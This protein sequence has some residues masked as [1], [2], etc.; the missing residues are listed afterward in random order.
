MLGFGGMVLPAFGLPPRRLPASEQPKAFG[1][2]AVSLIVTAWVKGAS[3]AFA[4][5]NS[6]PWS[7]AAAFWVRMTIAHGRVFSQGT[8]RGERVNVLLGRLVIKKPIY[9]C[10]Q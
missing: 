4:K 2:L 9:P 1:I 5:A 8:V 10:E 7:S 3:T 6:W